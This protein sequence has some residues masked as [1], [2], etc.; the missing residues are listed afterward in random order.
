MPSKEQ[1]DKGKNSTTPGATPTNVP[2][3][4]ERGVFKRL[5]MK[6]GER[7]GTVKTSEFPEDFRALECSVDN[8]MNIALELYKCILNVLQN[9]PE[10]VNVNV[11]ETSTMEIEAPPN[12]DPFELLR[13]TFFG[14]QLHS[15][16]PDSKKMKVCE[17]TLSE[18]AMA[19][20]QLQVNG[21]KK[22]HKLRTFL[23]VTW[24]K[25]NEEREKLLKLREEKD[26]A[27]HE[28]VQQP[29]TF[30]EQKL[31]A[32]NDQYERQYEKVKVLFSK[33]PQIQESH[34]REVIN[35]LLELAAYNE[36][37]ADAAEKIAD[38]IG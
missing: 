4:Q 37:C 35:V 38:L 2:A 8:Y 31:A 13:G 22:M 27:H 26:F 5:C 9:N 1:N 20:R 24:I 32:A 14:L 23:K 30:L 18:M 29:T 33:L 19:H 3:S 16:F 7:V 6:F 25:W 15:V 28:Y 11:S 17:D 21:R 36:A 10:F 34:R 12:S